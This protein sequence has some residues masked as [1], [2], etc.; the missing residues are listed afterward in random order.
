MSAVLFSRNLSKILQRSYH[1]TGKL[2]FL[3]GLFSFKSSNPFAKNTSLLP[4]RNDNELNEALMQSYKV[5]LILNFT[6]RGSN[7]VR[8]NDLTG[9]LTRIVLTELDQPEYLIN[10]VDVET[11]Y[12]ETMDSLLRFGVNNIPTLVA[13]K[14]TF[15]IDWYVPPSDKSKYEYWEDLSEWVKKNAKRV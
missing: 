7:N 8:C 4:V 2:Q 12:P 6:M 10:F 11:D 13:V 9:A 15:P 3:N 5:P 1:S 14:S